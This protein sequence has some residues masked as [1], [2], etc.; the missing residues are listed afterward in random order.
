MILPAGYGFRAPTPDDLDAIAA[1]L[2]ADDTAGVGQSVLGAGLVQGQWNTTGFDMATDAWVVL[3]DSET[4]IA[5]GHALPDDEGIIRSWGVVHPSHRS[6]GIGS[7]LLTR[8][9]DRAHALLADFPSGCFRHSISADDHAA[10]AMLQERGLRPV[11]HFW[12][13]GIDLTDAIEPGP[14]PDGIDIAAIKPPDD[15]TAVHAV[16]QGAFAEDWDYQPEPF[17]QWAGEAIRHP[18]YDPALWLMATADGEPVGALTATVDGDRGWIGEVGV[19]PSHRG[20]GIAAHLLRRSFATFARRGLKDAMLNV[21]SE[22]PTGATAV[23]ERAGMR[24]AWQWDL[25]ER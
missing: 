9:D 3:D 13:M 4:I 17:D 12:Y 25:W 8:I 24:T 18:N 6:R 11:R 21:D 20:R 10:A 19:L 23:Y 5:Y 2:I 1:V 15:L 22:N 7:W 16:L 14:A